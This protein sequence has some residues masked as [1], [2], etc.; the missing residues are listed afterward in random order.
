MHGKI[1]KGIGGFYYVHSEDDGEIYACRARG[2]FRKE[3]LKPLPG[4]EAVFEV[5]HEQ[6]REGNLVSIDERKNVLI[7]PAA[8]NIDGVLVVF[9]VKDPEP[10]LNLLDRFLIY[11]GAQDISVSIFFNKEDIHTCLKI[12]AAWDRVDIMVKL[13]NRTMLQFAVQIA[14][15][16]GFINEQLLCVLTVTFGHT[17]H[18]VHGGSFNCL[19]FFQ[20]R[21]HNNHTPSLLDKRPAYNEH[22]DTYKVPVLNLLTIGLY[23]VCSKIQV[24]TFRCD[25]NTLVIC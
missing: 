12:I 24:R 11:M 8:A 10:N 16:D 22:I 9:S 19:I 18:K 21:S 7:R 17:F 25:I 15:K 2:I 3:K 14:E 1:L 4:D 5:T 20:I 23:Y 6:D 13:L